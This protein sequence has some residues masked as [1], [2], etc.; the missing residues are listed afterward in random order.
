MSACSG[1][2]TGGGLRAQALKV[3]VVGTWDWTAIRDDGSGTVTTED[4]T[5]ATRSSM[6]LM[7][8][9]WTYENGTFDIVAEG[10]SSSLKTLDVP[11]D[12][13]NEISKLLP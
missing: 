3:F 12:V 6:K 10:L 1:S 5:S 8:G 9:T 4:G 7:S 11:A 2:G 13:P